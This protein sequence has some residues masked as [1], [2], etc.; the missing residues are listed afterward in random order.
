MSLLNAS[1]RLPSRASVTRKVVKAVPFPRKIQVISYGRH[2]SHKR[3]IIAH[4]NLVQRIYRVISAWA[5]NLVNRAEDPE[6]LLDHVVEEMQGDLVRMRHAAATIF[7]QKKQ[8]ENKHKQMQINAN[9]WLRRAEL[10]VSKGED[11]LAK[12]ALRRRRAFEDQAAALAPQLE[13]LTSACE[14]VLSNTR[15]L[16]GK[17]QEALAKK[18]TLK[19]RA[20]S[21]RTSAQV[22]EMLGGLSAGSNMGSAVAAFEKMEQK[23]VEMEAQTEGARLLAPPGTGGDS[24]EAQFRLLEG[25]KVED[26]LDAL[27]RGELRSDGGYE[28]ASNNSRGKMVAL[29]DRPRII[30]VFDVEIESLRKRVGSS[31]RDKL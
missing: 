1:T 29:P 23:V 11:D 28:S 4:A 12:E 14:S 8:I 15:I 13:Q 18:E 2:H 19:A 20:A 5:N 7:S 25:T 16:E 26:D 10:A 6:K 24:T 30:D 31:E 3:N 17:I 22:Q 27:K 9:D 21:A